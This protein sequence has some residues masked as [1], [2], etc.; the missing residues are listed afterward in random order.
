MQK[1][2]FFTVKKTKIKTIILICL[3]LLLFARV[4]QEYIFWENF[5]ENKTI[6]FKFIL[7]E[8]NDNCR[9]LQ[10][11]YAFLL[12]NCH[13]YQTGSEFALIGRLDKGSDSGF[14][15][16]KKIDIVEFSLTTKSSDSVMNWFAHAKIMAAQLRTSLI[17]SIIGYFPSTYFNLMIAMIFGIKSDG[18]KSL[19]QYFKIT[20]MQHVVAV[21]GFNITMIAMLT[22]P[23]TARFE[24]FKSLL[25]WTILVGGYVLMTDLSVSVIRALLMG[26]LKKSGGWIGQRNYHNLIILTMTSSILLIIKPSFLASASFQLSVSATLGIVLFMPLFNINDP[27]RE[28]VEK[29]SLIR[30]CQESILTTMSA[31]AFTLPIILLHF[32]QISLISVVAN[33][34][35]LWLTPIITVGG[36]A[37]LIIGGILHQLLFLHS[38]IN[39]LALFIYMPIKAFIV[40]LSYLAQFSGLFFSDIKFSLSHLLVSWLV[41]FALYLILREIHDKNYKKNNPVYNI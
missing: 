39:I 10:N 12:K 18:L 25:I 4:I 3:I 23:I 36:L 32:S 2:S 28:S 16:F 14:F 26:F 1:I 5:D 34:S 22:L 24:R 21:S 19:D 37:F 30:F 35:L 41:V 8:K 7:I 6:R 38:I 33:L 15:S 27:I 13:S 11:N 29:F 40:I 17:Q 20:G 9:F 31:Q